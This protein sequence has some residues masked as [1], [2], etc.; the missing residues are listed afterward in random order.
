M[1]LAPLLLQKTYPTMSDKLSEL[2]ESKGPGEHDLWMEEA[3][4]TI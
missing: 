3:K 2:I 4:G 1:S